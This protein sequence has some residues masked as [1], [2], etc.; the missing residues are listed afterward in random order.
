MKNKSFLLAATALFILPSAHALAA[1]APD[2]EGSVVLGIRGVDEK[3]HS[4]KFQE[5]RYLDDGVF[6]KVLLNYFKGSYYFGVKGKN[7]GQDDEFYMLQGGDYG[8]FKY[9]FSY[10]KIPHN[11]SYDAISFFS[12]IGTN[13]LTI[14]GV[15]PTNEALWRPFDYTVDRKNYGGEIEVSLNSPFFINIGLNRQEMDG[16]KPLGSGSFF[17]TEV[18]MPEPVDYTT[19]NFTIAGGYSSMDLLFKVSGMLSSF[20]NDNK[21]L[22]WENPGNGN[23]E[24]NTLPPDN[25]YGKIAANLTWRKLPLMST[26]LV[27]GSYSK[28]SNDFSIQ[29]LNVSVPAGLNR[30]KFD[31]DVSYTTLSGS[32]VSRPIDD[33][34]TRLYYDYLDKKND[35]TTVQYINDDG[36]LDGNSDLIFDYTK[37]DAGLD[38]NYDLA[39]QTKLGAGYEYVYI[40]RHNRPDVKNNT[41]NVLY[42]KLKN[43]SLD[44]LTAKVEYTYLNRDAD[45]EYE[46]GVT[47]YEPEYIERYVQRF[48]YT[49]KKKNE[50]KVILEL[51][52]I[53]TLDFGLEYTYAKND[54]DNVTLG[55]TEDKGH[56]FYVDFMWRAAQMLN[57]SG[58][59]GYEKYKAD[60]NHYNFSI[61]VPPQVPPHV[62]DPTIDDGNPASYRWSQF[63]DDD[64]WTL[65]LM[66]EMP[67]MRDRLKLSLSWQYQNS[68]GKCDFSTQGTTPLLPINQ[69]EDY[70]L[71]TVEAKVRYALTEAMDLA[72]GYMYERLDYDD[73]QYIGYEYQPNR[74]YLSGAYADHDYEAHI[75]YFTVKYRL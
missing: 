62:A 17:P 54:Y 15:D 41:D 71:T 31:G 47:I 48:D 51:Y 50:L 68:D 72:L 33:L 8:Q 20:N 7:I 44:F 21:Y 24:V 67:L 53:D 4:A 66:G 46:T 73:L 42:V 3:D 52:P 43:T 6:G 11:L 57:L 5:Y 9:S 2:V 69:S 65:A 27:N 23:N 28:L 18:E 63:L 61:T 34:T 55:R 58:F 74:S 49:S 60:S 38:V 26:L 59:V 56:E 36:E 10:D 64:F 37:H 19:D 22:Q 30:M 40:D 13:N 16:M 35:S 12:G 32:Y 70:D 1:D 75:G 25:D 29:E 45:Q 39:A 14:Q